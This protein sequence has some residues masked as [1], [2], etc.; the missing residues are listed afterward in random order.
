MFCFIILHVCNRDYTKT[1]LTARVFFYAYSVPPR[2]FDK[3]LWCRSPPKLN[4]RVNYTTLV[5]FIFNRAWHEV[6]RFSVKGLSSLVF[7]K[8]QQ[9]YSTFLFLTGNKIKNDLSSSPR[10]SS[11]HKCTHNA[12]QHHS[13]HLQARVVHLQDNPSR[14][15][16]L[17]KFISYPLFA[18]PPHAHSACASIHPFLR[19]QQLIC[20]FRVC[21]AKLGP[22]GGH[23]CR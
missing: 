10:L 15:A 5:L 22:A 12:P 9:Y 13:Q 2:M 21:R 14:P 8:L 3:L 20:F 16:P 1:K 4:A 23:R 7:V 11:R 18:S 17:E 6:Q 19:I